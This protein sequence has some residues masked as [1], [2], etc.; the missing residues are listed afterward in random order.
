MSDQQELPSSK[1]KTIKKIRILNRRNDRMK[2][3][4]N[5]SKEEATAFKNFYE[6]VNVN[7]NTEEEFVKAAFI[8]GLRTMEKSILEQMKAE[9]EKQQQ[10]EGVSESVEFVE[11]DD[12]E[13]TEE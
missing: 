12:T 10:E 5:L 8:L 13:K 11:E 6:A 3:Q 7:N 2:L 9:I 1:L 4:F